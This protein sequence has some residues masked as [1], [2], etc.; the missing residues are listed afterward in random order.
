MAR[1]RRKGWLKKRFQVNLKT[2]T[3]FSITY[4]FLFG[5]ALLISLS[6]T[7][8]GEFLSQ[9]NRW[10]TDWLGWGSF[11]LVF[12]LVQL[13]LMLT[14]LGLPW[15]QGGVF[16]GSVLLGVSLIALTQ[17]GFAGRQIFFY[18]SDLITT[19]GT[20]I[21][22]FLSS[23]VGMLIVL[24]TSFDQ[25][26]RL[27]GKFFKI[28]LKPFGLIKK[29]PAINSGLFSPRPGL[30]K[31]VEPV[32][33]KA[34]TKTTSEMTPQMINI[35][36]AQDKIWTFPPLSLLDDA[37]NKPADRGNTK[38]IAAKIEAT[39]DSF[40]V[41]AHVAEI[42]NGPAVTQYAIEVPLGTKL[43]RITGLANDLALN[44]AAPGGL[45]RIEAPIPGRSLVGIEV[46]NR[47]PEIVSLRRIISSDEIKATKSKLVVPLGLDVSGVPRV[48][49]IGRMPHIL[50]AG[51][52]GSGKSVLLN[53]WITSLMFRTT[54][55]ELKMI[56]IDPKR[57]EFSKY[58]ELPHLYVPVINE[59]KEVIKAL[60]WAA[61]HMDD[62][63]KIFAKSGARNIEQ[64]NEIAGFQAMPYLVI[65]IDEL[66]DIIQQSPAE[67]EDSICRIAQMAR[68]TGIHLVIATQRPSVDVLTGLIKANIP[69]RLSFAVSS[70]VDSRVIIDS[71]GAEKLLGRGD[72][73]YIPPDQA[74]P[75]RIQGAYVSD[76]E[77]DK[78]ADFLK[79]T[80]VQ[81]QYETQ[82][83]QTQI[84][85]SG[86][87][88]GDDRTG[89]RDNLLEAAIEEIVRYKQASASFLQRR[90]SVG[91][92]RAAKI[93]D[94]LHEA[95][96][97]GPSEGS[98]PRELLVND[99]A[100]ALSRLNPSTT[101]NEIGR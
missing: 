93:L 80:G 7:G 39:L 69:A 19:L 94:Q 87:S 3:I 36:G 6:F 82:V 91:Y 14:R 72:M 100:E 11:F 13:A 25:V 66:A 60:V 15:D 2:D 33:A 10:L 48:A 62:R 5:A 49:D 22:L 21:V 64:Y 32:T 70:L 85:T 92:S 1:R 28:L 71:P 8:Q 97:I 37:S 79:K 43:T 26:V 63:Y 74:K 35:P 53:A 89:E 38:E 29:R 27:L 78:L 23:I 90:L 88:S 40:G 41:P 77:I 47:S 46:P 65:I 86:R 96:I 98:K 31:T 20:Y 84:P 101:T 75:S 24:N 51:Q 18:L 83:S 42:N 17:S 12:L 99:V 4:L 57:V 73:L 58:K 61:S 50:I 76:T 9:L 68:A 30:I 16:A 95:G 59:P 67:V 55:N 45:I 81:P 56:L 44:L 52:T 54:P 34:V